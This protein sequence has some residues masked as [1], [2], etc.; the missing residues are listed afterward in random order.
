MARVDPGGEQGRVWTSLLHQWLRDLFSACV[1]Q[2]CGSWTNRDEFQCRA[3]T[4]G[5][6]LCPPS[7]CFLDSCV[8]TG[9]ARGLRH[10][11]IPPTLFKADEAVWPVEML[12][13]RECS[14]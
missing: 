4:Q 12:P 2:R 7:P 1:E 11:H 10:Q 3:A 8:Q 13:A 14:N 9:D 5:R 6:R